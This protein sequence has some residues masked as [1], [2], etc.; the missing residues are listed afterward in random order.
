MAATS[1]AAKRQQVVTTA[2]SLLNL[3]AIAKVS[4][5]RFTQLKLNLIE[6]DSGN[7]LP[8]YLIYDLYLS[9]LATAYCK[10]DQ[11]TRALPE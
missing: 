2:T 8:L 4:I 10:H 5:I 7:H 11:N 1:V 6:M 9:L 3:K